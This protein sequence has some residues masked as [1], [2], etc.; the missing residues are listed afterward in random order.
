MI[1]HKYNLKRNPEFTGRRFARAHRAAAVTRPP[2]VDLRSQLPPVFDQGTEG[3]CGPN[4]ADGLMC[5]FYPQIAQS[6]GGFSRQQIYY[7]VRELEGDVSKDDGIDTKDA[8]VILQTKGAAPENLWPYTPEN[9]FAPPPDEV[10]KAAS[11]Y[12][13]KSYSQLASE[14]DFLDCLAEGFP[15]MLGI[16]VYESLED[17]GLAQTGV[18]PRPNTM[19]EKELGGHDVLV[20]GYDTDFWN[21]PDFI[22][23]GMSNFRISNTALLIRN[24]WGASWGLNGHFWM[25]ID[26]ASNSTTGGDAWCGRI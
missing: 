23:S 15:F 3:S 12:K 10:L 20:V 18:Y 21:N 24:S 14:E 19:V 13:I 5:F 8:L 22:K 2:M 25:S 17:D 1:R 9:L 16:T 26:F 4:S 11:N 6:A 7:N